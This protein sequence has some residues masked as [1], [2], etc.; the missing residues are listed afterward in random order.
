M[1]MNYIILKNYISLDNSI[2]SDKDIK[3]LVKIENIENIQKRL[4]NY[5]NLENDDDTNRLRLIKIYYL[6]RE[7]IHKKLYE[8]EDVITLIFD[9]QN[10]KLSSYFY[11]SLSIYLI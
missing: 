9:E 7:S 4:I 2:N 3:E 8:N 5:N 11:L 10:D 1:K 6:Y